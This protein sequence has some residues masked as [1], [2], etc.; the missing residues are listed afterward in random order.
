[1]MD[2]AERRKVHDDIM[3]VLSVDSAGKGPSD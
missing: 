1:M 2:D 3:R